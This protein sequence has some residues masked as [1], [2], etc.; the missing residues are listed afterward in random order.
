MVFIYL[1]TYS[2]SGQ[3]TYEAQLKPIQSVAAAV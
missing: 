2:G 3:S 1:F